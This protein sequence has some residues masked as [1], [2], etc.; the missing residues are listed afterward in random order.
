MDEV[1]NFMNQTVKTLASFKD[2]MSSEKFQNYVNYER[3]QQKKRN[4]PFDFAGDQQN[5]D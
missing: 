3:S 4:K 5:F 1:N 2:I